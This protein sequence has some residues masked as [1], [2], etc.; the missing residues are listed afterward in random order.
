MKLL[1]FNFFYFYALFSYLSHLSD[2][3]PTLTE[4][5]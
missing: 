4:P 2:S 5:S 3:E 1:F